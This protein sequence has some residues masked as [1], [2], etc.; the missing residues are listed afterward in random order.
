VLLIVAALTDDA[1]TALNQRAHSLGLATLVEVHDTTELDR[2]LNA[3]ATIIGVNNRNLRT[4]DVDLRASDE[5]AAR[6]PAKVVAVSES[7]INSAND[8][9]RLQSIGYRAFLI[10]ERFMTAAN[11]GRA[12][13]TL[14]RRAGHDKTS[15]MATT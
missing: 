15:D 9:S 2:A 5:I 4:L 13:A 8:L 6:L 11:P 14:I 3:G 7:G 10:G 12:L 1:L